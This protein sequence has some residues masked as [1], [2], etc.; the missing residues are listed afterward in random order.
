MADTIV[1]RWTPSRTTKRTASLVADVRGER[2]RQVGRTENHPAAC[3]SEQR[4]KTAVSRSV[5][6]SG[7]RMVHA[8]RG[9]VRTAISAA[10]T[11]SAGVDG[12][13]HVI[14]RHEG[15]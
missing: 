3:H 15:R 5:D 11:A 8:S 13:V 12:C 9:V 14:I 10:N 6:N 4:Q 7:R 2:H 1:S